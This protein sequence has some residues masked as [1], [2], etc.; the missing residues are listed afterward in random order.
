MHSRR[1]QER[2]CWATAGGR[3][4]RFKACSMNHVYPHHFRACTRRAISWRRP[5]ANF[6][7]CGN[8]SNC[9]GY[10]YC[11]CSKRTA[12]LDIIWL[13]LCTVAH[14]VCAFIFISFFA[15]VLPP[16]QHV[17]CAHL[18]S[19]TG[20]VCLITLVLSDF[21]FTF[22]FTFLPSPVKTSDSWA[23]LRKMNE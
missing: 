14:G 5:R 20:H 17:R 23:P 15:F 8:Q 11:N 12:S 10:F 21:L 22:L 1:R 3:A 9:K 16:S 4:A 19:C 18:A 13:G 7:L 2:E 6:K